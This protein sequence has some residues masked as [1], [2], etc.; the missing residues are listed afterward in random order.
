[1][2]RSH[3]RGPPEP[4]AR[5]PATLERVDLEGI[6][7]IEYEL[8]NQG[9]QIAHAARWLARQRGASA[10]TEEDV[11]R[12][13]AF[14]HDFFASGAAARGDRPPLEPEGDPPEASIA[15]VRAIREADLTGG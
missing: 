3:P 13:W 11:D 5:A 4:R 2:S 14:W 1:M 10:P 6:D 15:W 7:P 12:A 8:T 9:P